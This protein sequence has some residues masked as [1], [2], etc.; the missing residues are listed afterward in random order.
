MELEEPMFEMLVKV[1]KER[2]KEANGGSDTSKGR[3]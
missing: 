2:A 3:S 1:L